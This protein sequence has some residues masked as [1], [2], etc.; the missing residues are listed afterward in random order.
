MLPIFFK[1]F[2][3]NCPKIFPGF[4]SCFF[5]EDVELILNEKMCGDLSQLFSEWKS[6]LCFS[7]LLFCMCHW[8]A[9]ACF[10][11]FAYSCVKA[12]TT[13]MYF[14]LSMTWILIEFFKK[15]KEWKNLKNIRKSK[16]IF[17]FKGQ[18]FPFFFSYLSFLE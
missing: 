1:N 18:V 8:C 10:L 9:F 12:V 6:Q 13:R 7:W 2:A 15:I 4:W 5:P 16:S 3:Q 11:S 17:A 14:F